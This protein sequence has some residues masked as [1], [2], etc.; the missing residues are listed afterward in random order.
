MKKLIVFIASLAM[1]ASF[2]FAENKPDDK[3]K[4]DKKDILRLQSSTNRRPNMPSKSCIVFSYHVGYL[5]F[6]FPE[7]IHTLKITLGDEMLP[8]WVGFVNKDCPDVEIPP[9]VG[10]VSITCEDDLGRKYTG[11]LYF[12][13]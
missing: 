3:N 8:I 9:I 11:T 1:F 4:L 13:D 7:G 5:S 2:G 12:N 6:E 10:E